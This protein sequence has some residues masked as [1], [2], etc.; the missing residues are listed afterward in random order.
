MKLL[1]K[2]KNKRKMAQCV[3]LFVELIRYSRYR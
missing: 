1:D 3:K 2:K